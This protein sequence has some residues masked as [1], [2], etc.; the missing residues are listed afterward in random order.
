LLHPTLRDLTI[1]CTDFEAG[2]KLDA[3]SEKHLKSTPLR[4]LTF[5]ECN[6]YLSLLS[7]AL[8][9]P[10][11]LKKLSIGER[12]Q[13]FE[14]CMPKQRPD[15]PRA[16]HPRILD[17]LQKQADS[18][19]TLTHSSGNPILMQ[20]FPVDPDGESKLQKMSALKHLELDIGSTL[21]PYI[22]ENAL[23][24]SLEKITIF[25]AAMSTASHSVRGQ[26]QLVLDV[27][28]NVIIK[29]LSRA[30]DLDICFTA[31]NHPVSHLSGFWAADRGRHQQHRMAVHKIAAVLKAR[32]SRLRILAERFEGQAYIPPYMYGEATPKTVLMYTSEKIFSFGHESPDPAGVTLPVEFWVCKEDWHRLPRELIAVCVRC[33]AT[34]T[35]C[36]N[37]GYGTGCFDCVRENHHCEYAPPSSPWTANALGSDSTYSLV[38]QAPSHGWTQPKTTG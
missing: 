23:P 30:I 5:I 29:R 27:A 12:L 38:E 10:K 16:S 25:D 13:A 28:H 33:E 9:L 7:V 35:P 8:A 32:G 31:S 6:I 11:A 14:G 37:G 26:L 4:S 34:N 36:Q 1:S 22:S 15:F 19:E 21:F 18:L 2:I 24:D 20:H 3:M 17:E